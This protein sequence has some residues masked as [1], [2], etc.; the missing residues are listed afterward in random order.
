M[1]KKYNFDTVIDR[2]GSNCVKYDLLEKYFGTKD[3]LP[4]WVADMDFPTPDF[5]LDAIRERCNHE[6]LGYPFIHEGWY[7]SILNWLKN[8]YDWTVEKQEIGFVPGIVSGIA[9]I[10]QCFT[11]PGDKI[12]IQTPVYP[13]FFHIPEKNGRKVVINE[14]AYR[15]DRLEIDFEDFEAK[16][17]SGCKMF[18]LCSPHNPGGRIWSTE[19]LRRMLEICER[20]QILVV[21]DEIH[22]DLTL[23]GFKHTPASSFGNPETTR[24]IT[25][26]A[27]SKSFN[28][29]GLS[30]SFY[31]IKN[32][33]L[34]NEFVEFLEKAEL[35]NGNIFAFVAPQA[36]YENGEDWLRQ[37]TGYLQENVDYVDHFLKE[38]LPSIKACRPEASFLIWLDCRA[39]GLNPQALHRLFLDEAKL[40]LNPGNSFGPGGEGFMRL[41]IGCPREILCEAMIRLKTALNSG[42]R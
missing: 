28:M 17:A 33:A 41:N 14:L 24:L 26:M 10:L 36:A 19:E 21:S 38:N 37:L 22:A 42:A 2:N 31:I 1:Q 12:L 23:P 3:A 7:N 34:R 29:P 8:R 6:I 32:I 15:N 5:I 20:Y 13:P 16:A 30:S 4:L 39:L 25:L 9:F 27:P 40:A 11:E 35:S 18:I